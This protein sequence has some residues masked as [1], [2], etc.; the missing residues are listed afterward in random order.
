MNIQG[1]LSSDFLQFFQPEQASFI[2]E[3]VLGKETTQKER[4]SEKKRKTQNE[5]E[6]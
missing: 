1:I 2:F 3:W 4:Q 5:R 6:D